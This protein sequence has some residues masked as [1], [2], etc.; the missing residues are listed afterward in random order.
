MTSTISRLI[1]LSS[2]RRC[3]IR[4]FAS[5]N[6]P[7]STRN[8]VRVSPGLV[9]E[10]AMRKNMEAKGIHLFGAGADE[11]P[12]CY[13]KLDEVLAFHTDSVAVETRLSPIIVC[14]GRK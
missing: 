6:L 12:D 10:D 1:G 11:A 5:S 2:W 9:D 3:F 14:I 13:K 8:R 7:L 4:W